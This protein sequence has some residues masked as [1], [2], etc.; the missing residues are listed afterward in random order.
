MMAWLLL[1]L[2]AGGFSAAWYYLARNP[3][4]R[5][6]VGPDGTNKGARDTE[7]FVVHHVG[8]GEGPDGAGAA[9][10]ER[11]ERQSRDLPGDVH[12]VKGTTVQVATLPPNGSE[13]R[14]E[15]AEEPDLAAATVRNRPNGTAKTSR[16]GRAK[17]RRRRDAGSATTAKF[18]PNPDWAYELAMDWSGLSEHSPLPAHYGRDTVVALVRNPHSLYVYW[19]RGGTA[20]QELLQQIGEAEWHRSTPCLRVT[21]TTTGRF[22]VIDV[23]DNQDHWFLHDGL[24]PGHQYVVSY[25]RRSEAGRYSLLSRSNTVF[26]PPDQPAADAPDLLYAMTGLT[27]QRFGR[28]GVGAVGARSG[29]STVSSPISS[30]R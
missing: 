9:L 10:Q 18:R 29:E 20:D 13:L 22:F 27:Q 24:E 12:E 15:V 17:V 25:E 6:K 14:M 11:T 19:E 21:D 7:S 16:R 8:K 4:P 30:W 23:S 28:A 5:A 1:A 3:H 2:L 26:M